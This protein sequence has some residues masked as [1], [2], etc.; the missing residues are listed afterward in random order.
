MFRVLHVLDHSRPLHSG[1]AF[2]TRAIMGA[3]IADGLEVK[4]I[5]GLRHRADLLQYWPSALHAQDAAWWTV[6]ATND[7]DTLFGEQSSTYL[8]ARY[9]SGRLFFKRHVY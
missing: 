4:G 3:Q 8:V 2:R 6:T 5:T 9:E 1:Y 7:S